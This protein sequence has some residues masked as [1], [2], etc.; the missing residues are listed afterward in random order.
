MKDSTFRLRI[1][2]WTCYIGFFVAW[3]ALARAFVLQYTLNRYSLCY[4]FSYHTALNGCLGVSKSVPTYFALN[5]DT[6]DIWII[7]IVST[8]LLLI[9]TVLLFIAIAFLAR[10]GK[11]GRP[12]YFLLCISEQTQERY[13]FGLRKRRHSFVIMRD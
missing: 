13:W 9:V 10:N 4:D 6:V 3:Y 2:T 1:F 12:F 5:S 7:S 8:G 11:K